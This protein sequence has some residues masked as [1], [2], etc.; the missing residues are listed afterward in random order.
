MNRFI[1]FDSLFFASDLTILKLGTN[2]IGS[3]FHKSFIDNQIIV[4]NCDPFYRLAIDYFQ[5]NKILHIKKRLPLL[6]IIDQNHYHYDGFYGACLG[7]Q[8]QLI[9]WIWKRS[10]PSLSMGYQGAKLMGREDVIK[11][12]DNLLENYIESKYQVKTSD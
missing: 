10:K 4:F 11:Y 12:L 1:I 9:D 6:T 3:Q 5:Y 7:G 2:L 8:F